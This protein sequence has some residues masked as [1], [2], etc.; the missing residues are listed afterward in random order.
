[1][2]GPAEVSGGRRGGKVCLELRHQN[3][4]VEQ[5]CDNKI[6]ELVASS[7]TGHGSG[8]ELADIILTD[9]Y[10]WVKVSGWK[11]DPWGKGGQIFHQEQLSV[12][13]VMV[14]NCNL[15]TLVLRMIEEIDDEIRKN[16]KFIKEADN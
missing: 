6:S 3:V 14:H 5:H 13:G 9:S 7:K 8:I 12:Q 11:I 1:M 10:L 2:A 16:K 15:S 4:Q